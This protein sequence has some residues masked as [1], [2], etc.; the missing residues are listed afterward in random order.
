MFECYKDVVS[1]PFSSPYSYIHASFILVKNIMLL[2][3]KIVWRTLPMRQNQCLWGNYSSNRQLQM[4]S[5]LPKFSQ[6][7]I[8]IWRLLICTLDS[9]FLWVDSRNHHFC[10]WLQLLEVMNFLIL[11]AINAVFQDSRFYK[12]HPFHYFE[13]L[14]S[15]LL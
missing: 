3:L 6:E 15:L 13:I 1:T 7:E 14:P 2:Y 8:E 5:Q 11:R 10:N 4:R 9:W 12:P